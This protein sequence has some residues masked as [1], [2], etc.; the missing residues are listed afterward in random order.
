MKPE[1]F[2]TH[3]H[4]LVDWMAD[5]IENARNYAV[6]SQVKPKDI[7]NRLPA[8]PPVDGEPFETIVEDFTRIILPGMTHWQHPSFFAYFPANSS[9]PSVLAEMLMATL[10]AQCMVWQ[11]S[12]AA[13]ELEERV[14]QWLGQMIGL[15]EEF[16]GVIQ[17]TASTAT[18]CSILTARERKTN[19]ETNRRGLTGAPPYAVYCSTETHSSI[20]KAVKIAGL[21][22]DSLRKIPVDEKF[23]ML[24]G[25]LAEAIRRDLDGGVL[26]L[27]AVA[28][29]GTTGSTAIDPL[30]E[31]ARICREHDTWLHVDAAYAGTALLLP[32][33]RW[34]SDG[35]EMA[36][37]F[38]F[39][40]HKWMFTNFDCS[41]YF[42][43]DKEALVRTFEIMPEYLKTPE[44]DRVNNYRDWGIQLGRRFRALKLWFVIRSY[45]VSGLQALI[46]KHLDLAQDLVRRIE[47]SE[48][49]E[50]MAPVPLNLLC[51]RYHPRGTSD[52]VLDSLN[53]RLLEAVNS[54][55]KM[56]VTHT[57]LNGAYVL[58]L[59]VGQTQVEQKD[60]DTAWETIQS[61]ASKL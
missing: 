44:D 6:R 41:A 3:A 8:K 58:R 42:I 33:L 20:E 49:F 60:I 9:P 12:P 52:N 17:D 45:G 30:R 16:S 22:R 1:E 7:I 35:V 26:P 39:N 37:T 59:C 25:A 10:G 19:Y 34:M 43:K 32:E 56:Y 29:V 5:Y 11:T 15:P 14:M 23:A 36:D 50:L 47:T 28:T 48:Q 57:K 40:P 27:C 24:P 18:L 31:I 2:R 4:D 46:R 53:E 55:G 21:G 61:E 13:A 54:T 51:F 38:V